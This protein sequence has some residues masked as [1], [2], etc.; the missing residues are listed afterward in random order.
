M[1]NGGWNPASPVA[2]PALALPVAGLPCIGGGL[3]QALFVFR[4]GISHLKSQAPIG[5]AHGLKCTA[6][7]W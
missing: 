5:A 7:P 4:Y 3:P 1:R 6:G 2:G